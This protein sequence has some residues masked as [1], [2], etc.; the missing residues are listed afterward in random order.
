MIPVWSKLR[1]HT[2]LALVSSLLLALII[3]AATIINVRQQHAL[4]STDLLDRGMALGRS[5]AS[6]LSYHVL[7]NQYDALEEL[8]I[9]SAEFPDIR[10]LEIIALNG[11]VLGH[12]VRDSQ[13]RVRVIFSREPKPIPKE[14]EGL[15]EPLPVFLDD[16]LSIWY[17]L[18]TSTKL[19]WLSIQVSLDTLALRRKQVITENVQGALVAIVL[20]IAFLVLVLIRPTRKIRRAIEI[21]EKLDTT[22]PLVTNESGGSYELNK[23]FS[24]LNGAAKRL[25]AQKAELDAQTIELRNTNVILDGISRAQSILM[26]GSDRF[27]A[28]YAA[29]DPIRLVLNCEAAMVCEFLGGGNNEH[30]INILAFTH[31]QLGTERL[32]EVLNSSDWKIGRELQEGLI[33]KAIDQRNVVYHSSIADDPLS[34]KRRSWDLST[35]SAAAVP[36]VR[37]EA[38]VGLVLLFNLP[39][40]SGRDAVKSLLDGFL[41]SLSNLVLN[42]RARMDA[43][44]LF[45]RNKLILE[46]TDEGIFGIDLS[47]KVTFVNPATCRILGYTMAE[48]MGS[49]FNIFARPSAECSDGHLGAQSAIG[50]TIESGK[51]AHVTDGFFWRKDGTSVPVAYTSA[52]MFS[53]GA[54][55]GVV[56]TF[57]DLTDARRAES[58]LKLSNERFDRAVSGTNDGLWECDLQ[59]SD[60]WCSARFNELLGNQATSV[61]VPLAQFIGKVHPDDRATVL[62]LFNVSGSDERTFDER[63]RIRGREESY[64]W[65]RMRG[66]A[67]PERSDTPLRVAG[68]LMDISEQ[69][70]IDAMKD[71]FVATVSHELRT[72][73]TSILGSLGLVNHGV[74]GDVDSR[75]KAMLSIAYRN[76]EKLLAIINDILDISKIEAGE[77]RFQIERLELNGFLLA[78]MDLNEGVAKKFGVR[79]NLNV[80]DGEAWILSDEGRMNQILNNLLSNAIKFTGENTSVEIRLDRVEDRYRIAVQDHGPGIAKEYQPFLFKKFTQEHSS[81]TRKVGGTGLGLS[82]TKQLVVQLGGNLTF[83]TAAGEGT[84]FFIEF[85]ACDLS[86]PDQRASSKTSEVETSRS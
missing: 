8:L 36:L 64:A 83:I 29:I 40:S 42:S 39:S 16:H 60:L 53:D 22:R 37:N 85:P 55:V 7:L 81:L 41:P 30:Q 14:L 31:Q 76:S 66:R 86:A 26:S 15:N 49:S 38:L 65:F 52:P 35:G 58:A 82:I 50:N 19:G 69:V 43:Q 44:D 13:D 68:S 6:T 4:L 17:P 57:L 10:E 74:V 80:L 79:L 59:T 72:P 71:E 63:C 3:V 70:R 5:M 1:L 20:D 9:K 77:V 56:V 45:E 67:Y 48:I 78:C 21:A 23:L 27:A 62:S 12:I 33:S 18:E 34:G 84:T 73:L 75:F 32:L 54:K 25:Q 24:A 2:Q 11:D 61:H 47:G 51:T 46:S 28:F